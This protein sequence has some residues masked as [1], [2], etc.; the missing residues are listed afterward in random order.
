MTKCECGCGEK[1]KSGNRFIHGH[2]RRGK[3]KEN[4]ESVR[5][6]AEKNT[7]LTK[8][9][10]EGKRRVAE[11]ITGK[12]P[13]Q[14]MIEGRK[15]QSEKMKGR[16]KENHEGV[17]RG[18]EKKRGRTKEE[19]K[20]LKKHSEKLTGRTKENCEYVRK[21]SEQMKGR[22]G[23]SASNWRGGLSFEPYCEKFNDDLKERIREFFGRYC[24]V[25][26]IGESE[27]KE[28]L[29]VHHVNYNKDM[30][31]DDS[32]PLFVPLCRSCHSKTNG[33]RKYWEE[34]FTIS[35]NYLTQGE[36]FIKK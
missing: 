36:C 9:N 10:N 34:F 27:L 21:C 22:T 30:C 6:A 23:E 18:A 31:C 20:Y 15:R 16:T 3:T 17:R 35:L 12:V 11:K 2:S 33:D 26:G 19:Y 13:T 1:V 7:G 28:K 24:Y 29:C 14:A 8:E 5:R 32:K 4:D 25:C